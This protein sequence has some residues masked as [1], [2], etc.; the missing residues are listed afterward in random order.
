MADISLST[1]VAQFP[2]FTT[3][4]TLKPAM[5]QGALDAATATCDAARWGALYQ[6]AV[7]TLAAHK[8]ALSPFGE[9][10]R[11]SSDKTS[12]PYMIEYESMRATLP[13]HFAIGGGFP[14]G[15]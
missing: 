9:N 15:W 12:S 2:E 8:L 6:R 7:F 3:A 13:T 4:S 10:Q 5:I 14:G 11:L 1:F